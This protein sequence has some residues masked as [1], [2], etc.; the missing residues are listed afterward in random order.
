MYAR[1]FTPPQCESFLLLGPRGTGKSSWLASQYPQAPL[2]DLLEEGTLFDLQRDSGLLLSRLQPGYKGPVIIDEVQKVPKLLDEVHR[3]IEQKRGLQFILSGSSAR[4]LKRSGVNLLAGRAAYEKFHPLVAEELGRDFS[5]R[6]ALLQGMLPRVWNKGAPASYLK[7]YVL[8]YVDQE[9]KLEGLSRAIP[10]FNRFLQAASLSQGQPVNVSNVAM[11]CGV[12]RRSVSNYFDI[13]ED[14]LVA[15]RLPIFA[16]R[17]KRE[18]IKHDKFYFFDCGVYQTIR[19]KGPLDGED[20]IRGA[21][22]ETLVMQHLAAVN[23]FKKWEYQLHYWHTRNHIEV[24]FVL[25]GS[26]GLVAIEVKSGPSIRASD[27]RGL[28]EFSKDYPQARCILLYGGN[29]NYQHD[30]IE[31]RTVASFLQNLSKEL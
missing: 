20:E 13:L 9:V 6:K 5:L 19:P 23:D 30:N 11:D 4:K 25:Y 16:R 26:R 27:L 24:D 12:E 7:G 10:E 1:M 14:I 3:L 17:A 2:F 18:L 29:K 21:A 8:T 28:T 22:L 31:V 15:T